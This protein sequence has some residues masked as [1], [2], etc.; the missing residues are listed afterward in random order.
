MRNYFF[1]VTRRD[2]TKFIVTKSCKHSE[3]AAISE[4]LGTNNFSCVWYSL[5]DCNKDSMTLM[6]SILNELR[7]TDIHE[8][9][10]Y[11]KKVNEEKEM[12]KTF[13]D[14]VFELTERADE[15]GGY[16]EI[17][18]CEEVGGVYTTTDDFGNE[19]SK[20]VW[21][22]YISIDEWSEVSLYNAD[23]CS[24]IYLFSKFNKTAQVE[25]VKVFLKTIGGQNNGD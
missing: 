13:Y 22:D 25:I 8:Y 15:E 3:V 16:V 19:V 5:E 24:D 9:D 23:D 6:R 11:I 20:H 1:I 14:K 7:F 2:F 12:F 21:V 10:T 18:L 4:S 17:L